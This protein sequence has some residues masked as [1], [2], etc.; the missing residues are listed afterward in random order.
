M[1]K[2]YF[3]FGGP[4]AAGKSS[5]IQYIHS[6][7]CSSIAPLIE[8]WSRQDDDG[9]RNLIHLQEMRQMII[10]KYNINGGIFLQRSDEYEIIKSDLKRMDEIL[11]ADDNRVFLDECNIFTLAHSKAHGINTDIY[12]LEFCKRLSDLD[13]SIIFLSIPPEVSWQRR[14]ERY[15][16]R[17]EGFQPDERAIIMRKYREYLFRL[18]PIMEELYDK[19]EFPKIKIDAKDPIEDSLI[20][21]SKAFE[22][23]SKR[24]E[25]IIKKRF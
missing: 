2:G 18:A 10:H 25:I 12:F 8:N 16:K 17:L 4:Q 7:Y 14:K 21:S 5:T 13:A 1:S 24:Y 23:M 11:Q 9:Y 15:E 6:K 22:D 19:I 20:E 3:V